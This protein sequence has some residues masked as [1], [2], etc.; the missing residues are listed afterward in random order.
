MF[1][2]RFVYTISCHS[3]WW[4][5]WGG[6]KGLK[7]YTIHILYT[8]SVHT[9]HTHHPTILLTLFAPIIWFKWSRYGCGRQLGWMAGNTGKEGSQSQAWNGMD[10]GEHQNNERT[11][12]KAH[13]V[14]IDSARS[15]KLSNLILIRTLF[16][17]RYEL[18]L[19][20][21]NFIKVN[22]VHFFIS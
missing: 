19:V 18:G 13:S 14:F 9:K 17:L 15:T 7:F 12:E 22:N 6:K 5:F 2:N 20:F 11:T 4:D 1:K 3:A 21:I 16:I 10:G 8:S